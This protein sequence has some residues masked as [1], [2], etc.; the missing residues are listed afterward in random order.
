MAL[1]PSMVL[2]SSLTLKDAFVWCVLAALGLVVCELDG[3]PARVVGVTTAGVVLLFLMDHLRDQTFVV[4]VWAFALAL[5]LGGGRQLRER[6]AI[7]VAVLVLVPA[8]L[9]Y[10]VAGGVVAR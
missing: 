5:V 9:G 10:G 1:L 3:P 2:W 6:A 8:L 4:A 7:G